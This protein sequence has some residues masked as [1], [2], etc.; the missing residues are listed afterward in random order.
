MVPSPCRLRGSCAKTRLNG[1]W[2]MLRIRIASATAAL[3]ALSALGGCGNTFLPSAGPRSIDVR[4]HSTE[5]D[6]LPYATVRLTPE[7]IDILATKEPRLANIFTDQRPPGAL[8]FGIGDTVSV[9]IFEA[10]AGGL[11]IP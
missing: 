9:T 5:P 4:T 10:A 2:G 11:F 6:A 7:V 1:T 3:M 8:R